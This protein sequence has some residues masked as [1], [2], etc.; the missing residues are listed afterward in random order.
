[1]PRPPLAQPAKEGNVLGHCIGFCAVRIPCCCVLSTFAVSGVVLAVG[2]LTVPLQLDTDF[3]A[4]MEADVEPVAVRQA[5][6]YAQEERS[7]PTKRRLQSDQVTEVNQYDLEVIYTLGEGALAPGLLGSGPLAAI[8]AF[9]RGLTALPSWRAFC[10]DSAKS[11]KPLCEYGLSVANYG[12]PSLNGTGLI[13]NGMRYDGGGSSPLM[14]GAVLRAVKDSGVEPQVF[15]KGCC[16]EA[17][18]A[19]QLRSYFRFEF[20]K[21][22]T[23]DWNNLAQ[24]VMPYLRDKV[25][26]G[27]KVSFSSNQWR[28]MEVMDLIW[29]DVAL[30]MGSI[31]FVFVYLVFHTSGLLLS[32]GSLLVMLLSVPMSF[33]MFVWMSGVESTS[34]ASLLSI[35]LVVGLGSDVVFVYTDLWKESKFLHLDVEQRVLWTLAH[36]GKASLATTATTSVSFFANLCSVLRPLREFGV[37]MGICVFLV[38]ILLSL[39]V[40]P[41]CVVEDR[42]AKRCRSLGGRIRNGADGAPATVVRKSAQLTS[43]DKI[44][45]TGINWY[46]YRLFRIRWCCLAVWI[47]YAFGSVALSALYLTVDT[48]VPD[49]IPVDHNQRR[50][51]EV[52]QFFEPKEQVFDAN[53]LP[54]APDARVCDPYGAYTTGSAPPPVCSIHWCEATAVP[55]GSS[56]LGPWSSSG[57]SSSAASAPGQECQCRRQLNA[58]TCADNFFSVKQRFLTASPVSVAAVEAAV[59]PIMQAEAA[60]DAGK[61]S[62]TGKGTAP[63]VMNHWRSGN[64]TLASTFEASWLLRRG[65]PS[66]TTCGWKE[67]CACGIGLACKAPSGWSVGVPFQIVPSVPR[68]AAGTAAGTS[69]ALGD[70]VV[71]EVAFGILVHPASPLLGTVDKQKAWSFDELHD[72]GEPWAQRNLYSFCLPKNMPDGLQIL[73][74]FCWTTDF[75]TWLDNRGLKFP[76]PRD[77]FHPLAMEFISNSWINSARASDFVWVRDGRIKASFFKF[78]VNMGKYTR[79]SEALP[80]QARWDDYVS[81]YNKEASRF[82]R[83]AWHSSALWGLTASS[84]ML[85]SSTLETLVVLFVIAFLGMLVFTRDVKLSTAVVLATLSVVCGLAFFMIVV[86]RWQIGPIE[87]IALIVFIGYAATYSLHIAHSFGSQEALKER[88]MKGLSGKAVR[89]W[90]RTRFALKM[91]G[92]ATVGSALTTAGCATF[93]LF[94]KIKV[95]QKLGGVILS[96]TAISIVTA[97]GPL[98]ASLLAIGPAEPATCC[99]GRGRAG[100]TA[101]SRQADAD[102]VAEGGD[103][104]PRGEVGCFCVRDEDDEVDSNEAWQSRTWT[105]MQ[106]TST[107]VS[108]APQSPMH[109]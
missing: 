30:A 62:V 36:A 106:T 73:Q 105:Q 21:D 86:Q 108:E 37:F 18:G 8:A 74:S 1:M 67:V 61:S 99:R 98:P 79:P 22:R 76:V 93:L 109:L 48:K 70:R 55:T 58:G 49:I 38:W 85:V 33:I 81:A 51:L 17:E 7:D 83:D 46:V 90:Q 27:A 28:M 29:G 24:S 41:L 102:T 44:R 42:C 77:D 31:V 107:L 68:R 9:E 63:T 10:Q 11:M 32:I 6:L 96:I 101:A 50:H 5:F 53:V 57:S 60:V 45:T 72:V 13:P 71:V 91:L 35:Y 94:C 97:L 65:S 80:Y 26:A 69:V 23:Q 82:A 103:R 75:C 39:V 20:S 56:G 14:V 34:L 89:R 95:F 40:V 54:K 84:S 4:F 2:V 19:R 100:G 25:V 52:V 15:P 64:V 87:V 59:L 12:V 47:L 92:S 43:L 88:G 3:G 78:V 16:T 104:S 66:E